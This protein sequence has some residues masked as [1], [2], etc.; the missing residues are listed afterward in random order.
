MREVGLAETRLTRIPTR[1]TCMVTTVTTIFVE[2]PKLMTYWII[3]PKFQTLSI[4][5]S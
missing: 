4:Q 5:P 2:C 3:T 1:P